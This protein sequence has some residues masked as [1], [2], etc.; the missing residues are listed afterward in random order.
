MFTDF[1]YVLRKRKVPVSITEWMTLMEALAKGYITTLDEFYF[2]A[3]AILVKS[4]AYF[5]HY[6]VA[7]QEYFKGIETPAEIT[8][9]V[10]EWLR[11]PLNRIALTE[12][13]RALF[14]SMDFDEL[15]SELE[16]RLKE[17]TEQHDGGHYWIGRGGTSPFGHSGSHSA[18]IR[19]GGT[20]GGGH[21]VQ[22]AHDRRFR[23]YRHDLTLD[24]R[25]VEVA[26]KGLRQLS[27]L[28]PEDELDLEET[29]ESAAKNYGEI[30]LIWR[31]SRKNAAKVLLLM[32]VGGSMEP[33]A[34]LCSQLF[35]A[36]HRST[37]FKE[38]HYYYFHNCVYDKLYEDITRRE[39]TSTDHLLRTMD[40]NFKVLLVG[41]ATMAS[42]E[43]TE[44]HGAINYYDLNE[45][46][47]VV[48]LKRIADHFKHCVWLNVESPRYWNHSTV[49]MIGR[50]FPMY[51][52]SIDGLG[53]A[54]KKLLV[55]N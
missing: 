16:K 14:D 28:G 32:D 6:D 39:A 31:R 49:R 36:S 23:N 12:E 21:A 29:I 55:K 8:E 33:Y 9:Q 38:F 15:I 53:Q 45:T 42:S 7:F 35:S 13:E 17:Q 46:P 34:L 27:R 52:L 48:W 25:Q 43:L 5:D 18:G 10:L 2:L 51:P 22:I 20:G 54:M 50:I 30:E 26:L 37:H 3:R 24:I 47:G 11:D 19:V 1:F 44:R 41:D 4:E 40:P